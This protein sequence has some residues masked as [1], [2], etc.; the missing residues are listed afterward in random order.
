MPHAKTAQ[1]VAGGAG[2]QSAE[3]INADKSETHPSQ[4]ESQGI[5]QTLQELEQLMGVEV[6]KDP[7]TGDLEAMLENRLI[8]VLTVYSPGRYYLDNGQ[9]KGLTYE[10]FKMFENFVNDRLGREHLRVHVVLIPLARESVG[11][12]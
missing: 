11:L 9:E 4:P 6:F 8:R 10:W 1:A 7:W 3:V 12:K 5:E 2:S